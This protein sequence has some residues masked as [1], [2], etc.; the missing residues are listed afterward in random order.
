VVQVRDAS[1]QG[2]RHGRPVE[3][4]QKSL[5][6]INTQVLPGEARPTRWTLIAAKLA[7]RLKTVAPAQGLSH[8][9]LYRRERRAGSAAPIQS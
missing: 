4:D 8:L 6:Q 5:G 3:L 7:K 2:G 9:G 1:F